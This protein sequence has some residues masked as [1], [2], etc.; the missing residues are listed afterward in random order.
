MKINV[1]SDREYQRVKEEIHRLA[2]EVWDFC[3]TKQDLPKQCECIITLCSNDIRHADR[4]IDLYFSYR[5]MG[6]QPV[7]IFSGRC[8][9]LTESLYQKA[10]AETFADYAINKNVPDSHLFVENM[11]TNTG[12]NIKFTRQK[13]T[14]HNFHFKSLIAVTQPFGEKRVLGAFRKQWHEISGNVVVTSPQLGLSEYCTEELDYNEV[15]NLMIGDFQRLRIY[16]HLG[17]QEKFE[18]PDRISWSAKQ[19]I[20]YGYTKYLIEEVTM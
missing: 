16:A 2:L 7:V 10:E 8:G 18:I 1:D 3:Q 9:R 5:Q 12:E 20:D 4:A 14:D 17:F 11:S 19:L 13:L 15:I 6:S